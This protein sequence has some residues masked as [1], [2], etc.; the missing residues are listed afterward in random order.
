MV[1]ERDRKGPEE[2]KL[3]DETGAGEDEDQGAEPSGFFCSVHELIVAQDRE[4]QT[5]Q[6]PNMPRIHEGAKKIIWVEDIY[7]L[8]VFVPSWL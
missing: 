1:P 7:I 8:G 3:E 2:G 4:R 6:E 5:R